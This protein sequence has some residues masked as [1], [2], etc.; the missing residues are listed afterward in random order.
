MKE[1]TIKCPFCGGEV[2]I[3]KSHLGYTMAQCLYERCRAIVSFAGGEEEKEF[4]RR[5]VK[6]ADSNK[7]D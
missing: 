7:E 3:R 4:L 5:F 6:R 1:E 2:L